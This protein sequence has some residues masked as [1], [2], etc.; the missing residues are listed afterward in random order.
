MDTVL[1]HNE[2]IPT[3]TIDGKP[4]TKGQVVDEKSE[5]EAQYCIPTWLRDAQVK[6]SIQ[7]IKKRIQPVIVVKQEPLALVCFG[8]SLNETWPELKN[9]K[10]IMTCSGSYKFLREKGF[11]PTWHVDVDPRQHKVKLLGDDISQDTE[12]LIASC[13]H[14][15][16]FDHLES[17]N[18]NITLWHSYSGES[19]DVVLK[20]IPRGEW[21]LTGGSNVGLRALIIA[22]FLGFTNIHIFGLDGNFPKDGNTHASA[23]PNS[24][25]EYI[26]THVDGIEYFTTPAF[27]LCARQFFHEWSLLPDV[28]ITLH[29]DGM[30]QHMAYNKMRNRL[31][32]KRVPASS[33]A[34]LTPPDTIS[35]DYIYQ[36]KMLH[37]MDPSY[38]C[39][40]L[41]YVSKVRDLYNEIGARTLLDYGC[42]KGMLARNLDFPIWEYDPA[43]EGKDETARP[44]DLVICIDV[45]EHIEQDFLDKALIDIKR[46]TKK[47]CFVILNTELS[48]KT[49]PDGRN[50]HLIQKPLDWWIKKIDN[51]FYIHSAKTVS[52]T[53]YPTDPINEPRIIERIEIQIS[54]KEEVENGKN[55]KNDIKTL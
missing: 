18:A 25:K 54:P 6:L 8:P 35:R 9:F 21:V 23:H 4:Y 28:N 50:A 41:S 12:F 3:A 5:V 46:C 30:I 2:T 49:L 15:V 40:S 39:S 19:G 13:C 37:S 52:V 31:V 45:L 26:I 27:F 55:G 48:S 36:N 20:V 14:P 47:L 22:R 17:H 51:Y 53:E 34:F 33:I 32:D 7:R 38:G 42:G 16:L 11:T 24:P 29:G 43:I 10:Y 44:A 1:E